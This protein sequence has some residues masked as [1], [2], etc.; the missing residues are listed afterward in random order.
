MYKGL[1]SICIEISKPQKNQMKTVFRHII[2]R[3]GYIYI[4]IY[5]IIYEIKK[6]LLLKH[7]LTK[8][9]VGQTAG[10][11]AHTTGL[12]LLLV[13]IGGYGVSFRSPSP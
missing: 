9:I 12:G 6:M 2:P 3:E 1:I 10:H 8:R 4:Y 7:T 13:V 5:N 11:G